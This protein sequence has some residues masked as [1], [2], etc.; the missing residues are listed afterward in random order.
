MV[1]KNM[2]NEKIG[3]IGLGVMGLPMS[4]RLVEAGYELCVFDVNP[5]P[6]A[7]LERLGAQKASSPRDVSARAGI[8]IAIL[9]IPTITREV[10]LGTDGAIH[11]FRPGSTFVDMSTSNPLITLEIHR[12]LAGKR[13]AM[14]DAPVSG[15]Q[16]GAKEGTLM[17]MVGGAEDVFKRVK[18]ILSCLGKRI[19]R[20][21]KIG[22]GHTIKIINNML[23]AVNMAATSEALVLGK[24][25]GI[26]PVTLR[27][28]MNAG[29]GASYAM[30]V[31]VKEFIFRRNFEP[32]FTV[33]LQNK[34]VDLAIDLAKQ[35]GAP[36]VLGNLVRQIY[37]TLVDKGLGKKDSSIIVSHFE[38][39]MGSDEIKG[40][41][42][43]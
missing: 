9:P 26:D 14:I 15:G 43:D 40:N 30:D 34:D 5:E 28:V 20:V 10:V 4:K 1:Q 3:F 8:V 36:V 21:G 2:K 12:Y 6:I 22:S 18:P 37:Q 16:K 13:V 35:L 19:M 31:K 32:G 41:Y 23:Y 11:G 33:D 7:V 24:K 39:S 29:S 38:E 42:S 25:A 17:I 27:D